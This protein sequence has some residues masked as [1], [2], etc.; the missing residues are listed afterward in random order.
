M[1]YTRQRAWFDPSTTNAA[2][3]I[4]GCGGIGSFAAFA[5]AKLGVQTLKLVDF[6]TV[7]EH[8]IPNQLFEPD[9][10]GEPK[11]SALAK[12]IS[13][14]TGIYPTGINAPLQDGIP[15]S[16]IVVSALDSMAARAE[17]WKQVRYKLDV[18]LFLDGRLGGEHIVLY[19]VDPSNP[20]DV[21]GYETTLH[22]DADGEDLP[23]TARSIIDVGFAVGSLITR[24]VR[25]YYAHEPATPTVYLNQQTLD[26]FK[27][28]WD[29]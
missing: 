26:I 13:S 7:D 6:D 20:T 3:T 2:A 4:V 8:N 14:A 22:S 10:L 17:L 9:Q 11:V 5:L 15:R 29:T 27:G 21:A 19:S 23:C 28:G 24:A 18:K 1:D 25:R 16:P 12:N